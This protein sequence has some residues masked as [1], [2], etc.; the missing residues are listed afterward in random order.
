MIGK[1][2]YTASGQDIHGIED[3]VRPT[4]IEDAPRCLIA[5]LE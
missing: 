5:S 1:R 4:L 3:G 2:P